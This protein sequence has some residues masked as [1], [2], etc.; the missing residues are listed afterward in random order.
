MFSVSC[1]N[2]LH[3]QLNLSP[4]ANPEFRLHQNRMVCYHTAPN[5]IVANTE[6]KKVVLHYADILALGSSLSVDI[7]VED[8]SALGFSVSVDI[9]VEHILVLH[10]LL[11]V[12]IGVEHIQASDMDLH[13][14]SS[15]QAAST[16]KGHSGFLFLQVPNCLKTL[17]GSVLDTVPQFRKCCMML[18]L[19]KFLQMFLVC[20]KMNF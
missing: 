16:V 8:I 3:Y 20:A 5:E 4:M 7:G 10:S 14:L 9:G 15:F 19:L 11:S 13:G 18:S 17:A 1:R 6:Q 2:L 12:D